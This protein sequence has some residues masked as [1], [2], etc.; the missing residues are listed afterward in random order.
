MKHN[1]H[2]WGGETPNQL[3]STTLALRINCSSRQLVKRRARLSVEVVAWRA[4]FVRHENHKRAQ[5]L[6][7]AFQHSPSGRVNL[8]TLALDARSPLSYTFVVLALQTASKLI[9]KSLRLFFSSKLCLMCHE[10]SG[11]SPLPPSAI[12]PITSMFA[13]CAIYIHRFRYLWKWKVVIAFV[14]MLFQSKP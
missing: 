4:L 11:D 5:Q 13:I 9:Y 10:M 6:F 12:H 14:F 3:Y 2:T 8:F 1:K 7:T